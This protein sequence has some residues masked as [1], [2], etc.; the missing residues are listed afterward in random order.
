MNVILDRALRAND[1]LR[2]VLALLGFDADT[3]LAQADT[4][5]GRFWQRAALQNVSVQFDPRRAAT[6]IPR[7]SSAA[8]YAM[9]TIFRGIRVHRGVGMSEQINETNEHDDVDEV[10]SAKF[11]DASVPGFEAEFSPDEA[12]RAGAFVEDALSAEDALES[13]ADADV[14]ATAAAEGFVPSSSNML[15]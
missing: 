3:V 2:D 14:S 13:A 9:E 1:V 7:P 11:Q 10:V 15:Q 5:A 4:E 6:R 8:I 12:Q